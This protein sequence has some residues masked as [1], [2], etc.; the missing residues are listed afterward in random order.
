MTAFR[1]HLV[2]ISQVAHRC[3]PRSQPTARVLPIRKHLALRR[4]P[5]AFAASVS[6]R[7]SFKAPHT[8]LSQ[9]GAKLLRK[10]RQCQG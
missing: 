5:V 2:T 3:T 9:Q 7:F 4:S 6:L 10:C 1:K 8:V